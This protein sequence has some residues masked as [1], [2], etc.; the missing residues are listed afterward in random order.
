MKLKMFHID[1]DIVSSVLT[2][3]N[4]EY[5][6]IVKITITRGNIDK[7]LGMTIGCYFRGKVNLS[8]FNY[9]G[10]I[11]DSIPEDIRV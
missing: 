2:D 11:L 10:K 3:I 9:I 5:G 7:Y 4:A 6:N 8:M 1:S